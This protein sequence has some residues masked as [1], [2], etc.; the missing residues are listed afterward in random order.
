M[1]S[2]LLLYCPPVWTLATRRGFKSCQL[3]R[4]SFLSHPPP[5][6]SRPP[7][8]TPA[9]TSPMNDSVSVS[10]IDQSPAAA[11]V[12]SWKEPAILRATVLLLILSP[13]PLAFLPA[14]CESPHALARHGN[15]GHLDQWSS[16]GGLIH[17]FSPLPYQVTTQMYSTALKFILPQK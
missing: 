1:K 16:T 10:V 4:N 7:S 12:T 6:P 9:T 3:C 5:F 14:H 17:T 2:V 13:G 8:P 11:A 15:R